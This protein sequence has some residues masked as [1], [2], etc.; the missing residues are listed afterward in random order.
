MRRTAI[1]ISFALVTALV[2]A[3]S[4]ASSTPPPGTNTDGGPG[5][6]PRRHTVVVD[7]SDDGFLQCYDSCMSSC[8]GWTCPA[9]C[10]LQCI[11]PNTE[12]ASGETMSDPDAPRCA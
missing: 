4:F 2:G 6:A 10:F 8:D 7:Q 12:V 3:T 1:S 9:Y 11:D 5:V